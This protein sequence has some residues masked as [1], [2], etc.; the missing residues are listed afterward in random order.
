MSRLRSDQLM[1]R[2]CHEDEEGG[3]NPAAL[4]DAR[5]DIVTTAKTVTQL[6]LVGG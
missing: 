2:E 3:G 6:E 4:A 5:G 1:E